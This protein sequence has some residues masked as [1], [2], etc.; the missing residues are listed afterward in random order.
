MEPIEASSATGSRVVVDRE[1]TAPFLIRTFVKIGG[2]HR[3]TL[4]DEGVLPTTDEQQIFTWKDATL[5]EVL[6]IL[7]MTA[8]NNAEYRHPLARYAF[9]ALY[10]DS[11]H[12]GNFAQKDLGIVYSRDI[13]GEP[14]SLST[15]A[16]RLQEDFDGE[17]REL[18]E[19]EKE[20]RTLEELRFMPGDFLSISV[21][22]PKSVNLTGEAPAKGAATAGSGGVNGWKND[23][24]KVGDGGWGGAVAAR[25]GLGAGRGGGHWRGGSDAPAVPARGRGGRADPPRDRDR[26]G[27]DRDRRVPPPRRPRDSPPPRRGRDSPPP[28]GGRRYTPPRSRSPPRRRGGRYD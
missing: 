21:L 4:F 18:S 16:I 15:P 28:R 7:R 6:T 11:A 27:V 1:K 20:E 5:R 23:T 2:F 14:G 13:L 9:R 25:T 19:R 22:L 26:P 24:G 8:P 12:R 17:K 3:L 10:A